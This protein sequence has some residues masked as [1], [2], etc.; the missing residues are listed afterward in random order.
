MIGHEGER[1]RGPRWRLNSRESQ[2]N[3]FSEAL[4][5]LARCL[6]AVYFGKG[7]GRPWGRRTERISTAI[8]KRAGS[9]APRFPPQPH[10]ASSMCAGALQVSRTSAQFSMAVEKL[11][12]RSGQSGPL[13]TRASGFYAQRRRGYDIAAAL[14]RAPFLRGR[15]A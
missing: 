8:R 9:S 10:S 12:G 15:W 11:E 6:G 3:G 4:T 1:T 7:T 5:G 13:T 2:Q 14:S